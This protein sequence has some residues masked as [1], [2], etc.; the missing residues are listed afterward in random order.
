MHLLLHFRLNCILFLVYRKSKT[1]RLKK[2]NV[3]GGD[4]NFG[5]WGIRME[6]GAK[7]LNWSVRSICVFGES[8][9][10]Q[11]YLRDTFA[12]TERRE[13]KL[14]VEVKVRR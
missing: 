2:R 8:C 7:N 4:N 9:A 14:G 10:S 3:Q 13:E 6:N 12:V 11:K 1:N 5:N